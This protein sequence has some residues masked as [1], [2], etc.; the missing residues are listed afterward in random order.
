MRRLWLGAAPEGAQTARVP[1]E[2]LRAYPRAFGLTVRGGCMEPGF[3]DGDVVIVALERRPE[4]G[5]TAAVF[6]VGR[7]P[8]LGVLSETPGTVTV[9]PTNPVHPPMTLGRDEVR[10]IGSV[11]WVIPGRTSLG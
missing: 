3:H 7:E 1:S 11:V 4:A 8:V 2:V 10:A 6:P 9:T 5:G